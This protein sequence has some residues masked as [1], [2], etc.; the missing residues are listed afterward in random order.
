[1]NTREFQCFLADSVGV[2]GVAIEWRRSW[3]SA[4]VL[5][6]LSIWHKQL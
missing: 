1:M 3:F 5:P 6:F 4:L 2:L